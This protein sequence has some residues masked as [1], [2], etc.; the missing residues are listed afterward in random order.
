MDPS[1][2]RSIPVSTPSNGI[3]ARDIVAPISRIATHLEDR[4][5]PVLDEATIAKVMATMQ[6]AGLMQRIGVCHEG[7]GY[8]L[9]WGAHRLEAARRLGWPEIEAR[10][11]SHERLDREEMELIENLSRSSLAPLDHAAHIS[12]LYEVLAQ[13]SGVEGGANFRSVGAAARWAGKRAKEEVGDATAKLAVAYGIAD[14]IAEKADIS[15][16][17]VER[18]LRLYR[19]FERDEALKLRGTEFAA[20]AS[21]LE[22]LAKLDP[23]TRAAMIDAIAQRGAKKWSEA[24]AIAGGQRAQPSQI[25]EAQKRMQRIAGWW[26]AMSARER[27]QMLDMLAA[28]AAAVPEARMP[29]GYAITTPREV[30]HA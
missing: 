1:Y 4:A 9:V 11:V 26:L 29:K 14:E 17:S 19:L 6:R 12:R 30:S 5:T 27:A 7:D 24:E 18:A 23:K 3:P 22:R 10:L 16:R 20:N 25:P 8:R 21:Q 28:Q 13:R 2:D 15:K